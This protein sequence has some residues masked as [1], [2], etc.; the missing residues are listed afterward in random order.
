MFHIL[1]RRISRITLKEDATRDICLWPLQGIVNVSQTLAG[2][3]LWSRHKWNCL[4]QEKALLRTKSQVSSTKRKLMTL[5]RKPTETLLNFVK[6]S[7]IKANETLLAPREHHRVQSHVRWAVEAPQLF[8]IIGLQVSKTPSIAVIG[9]TEAKGLQ[10]I[11]LRIK[12]LFLK[13]LDQLMKATKEEL[14]AKLLTPN[15]V[16]TLEPWEDSRL[17]HLEIV[18]SNAWKVWALT[19]GFSIL[20][21]KSTRSITLL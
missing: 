21:F 16:E 17:K 3:K 12:R 13:K 4:K 2:F 11:I 1:P 14:P 10:V 7:P 5:W 19:K 18:I 8:V 6:P 20:I 9:C 15:F